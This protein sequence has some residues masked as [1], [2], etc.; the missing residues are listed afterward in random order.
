MQH[1]IKRSVQP[2]NVVKLL[3][4]ICYTHLTSLRILISAPWFINNV[5]SSRC[6]LQ[7][8]MCNTVHL[9]CT[10]IK[11]KQPSEIPR[12]TYI[13]VVDNSVL[14]RPVEEG[15]NLS[16]VV[17]VTRIVQLLQVT[18]A[19]SLQFTL[20]KLK[21]SGACKNFAD[22]L[23]FQTEFFPLGYLQRERLI[24]ALKSSHSYIR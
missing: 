3:W 12:H 21:L 14:V 18:A 10:T 23:Q 16:D 8:H 13:F 5:T 9:Y 17:V 2:V 11:T 15:L 24:N 6:P 7:A 1:S 19:H 4:P 22:S 20:A